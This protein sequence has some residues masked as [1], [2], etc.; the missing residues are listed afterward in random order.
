MRRHVGGL[1]AHIQVS[2]GGFA[3]TFAALVA[4]IFLRLLLPK[5]EV[6][7]GRAS[8]WF[9]VLSL[10]LRLAAGAAIEAGSPSAVSF[11][12]FLSILFMAFGMT[13]LAA[14]LIFDIVLARLT[15]TVPSLVRDIL[16]A[17][18]LGVITLGVLSNAGVNLLS[19][20]TTSA[21][22]TAVI[23]LALQST[24]SNLFA[25]ISLQIDRTISVGDWVQIGQRIGKITQIKWRSTFLVTRD[26]DN[27]ILPNG[28]LLGNEVLNFSKPTTAH[29]LWLRVGFAYRHPPNEVKRAMLGALRG[30]PGVLTD[31]PSD[32]FPVEFGESAITYALRYWIDDVQ[33][34]APIEGEIRTRIWYAAQ[35]AGL[36]L[37]FPV[38]N[39]Y[40]TEVTQDALTRE[41]EREFLER[42]AALARIDL[43]S[44]LG[45]PDRELLAR[46]MKQV[47]FANGEQIIRQGEPGDSLYL[48]QDGNVVVRLA[49]EG[50]ERE[51]ASLKAGD[52]FG[53]MSL[54]TGEKRTATCA[55][56]SDVEC[57]VI[58]HE[59][60]Q[61][62]LA[63][64]PE[65]AVQISSILGT[66]QGMLEGERENLSAEARV[67]RAA[68]NSSKLLVRIRNFFNLG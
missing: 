25:G 49:V 3:V 32:C 50:A 62:V 60:F 44:P 31:H 6:K 35:R 55:A 27:V 30:V 20:I 4:V 47:R 21:V 5:T 19:L 36:E 59:A 16:Q 51:V 29:R 41:Q 58:D 38:R 12:S 13:G 48:I 24:I 42:V 68:E 52:F 9:L 2:W 37:P 33:K 8:I 67:R 46:T 17:L 56:T 61:R 7:R 11:L 43:F 45:Q 54:M 18:T 28:V 14:M 66:R 65:V 57:Y 26:G 40:L 23:G 53:E 39:V 1:L 63:A 22:L 10:V 15:V 64:K 34:E